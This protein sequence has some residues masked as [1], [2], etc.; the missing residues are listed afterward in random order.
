MTRNALHTRI[1][2]RARP[3]LHYGRDMITSL[4]VANSRQVL[5]SDPK[6]QTGARRDSS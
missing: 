1:R 2:E 4:C 5:V 6:R 3:T